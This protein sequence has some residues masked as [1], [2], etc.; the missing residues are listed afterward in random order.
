VR[1]KAARGTNVIRVKRCGLASSQIA[2]T[3]LGKIGATRLTNDADWSQGGQEFAQVILPGY[4]VCR[5]EDYIITLPTSWFD[6]LRRGIILHHR[7]YRQLPCVRSKHL[8][9][10]AANVELVLEL[11]LEMRHLLLALLITAGS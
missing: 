9:V 7:H 10:L 8:F 4:Q 11:L 1:P 5:F 3:A 2:G 6:A